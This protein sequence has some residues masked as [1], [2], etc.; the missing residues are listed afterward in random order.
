MGHLART[1]LGLSVVLWASSSYAIPASY[2]DST[3]RTTSWQDLSDGTDPYGVSWSVDNGATWGRDEM[4][5]G[6]TVKFRFNM[7][8]SNVGTHYADHMKAWV[9]W[10]GVQ[11][12][13]DAVDQIAYG[14]HVIAP[15]RNV[16][17][18]AVESSLGSYKT[19]DTPNITYFSDDIHLTA[20][21]AGETW[22]RAR[23]TCSHSIV[24]A[25]GDGWGDQWTSEYE[26]NYESLFNPTGY[27]YQGE[28][29]EWKLTVTE[30]PEPGSLAL[31]GLG[32]AGLVASRRK[33]K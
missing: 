22:L 15:Q 9:D 31:L 18:T 7:H 27:L 6:E 26:D 33:V 23:V 32:L 19:P 25:N 10:A 1:L 29:E 20:A 30:V 3:H 17:N 24:K 8:K 14:E 28:T 21:H 2:G 11:G 5:V 16:V 13:F 4:F 12:Q